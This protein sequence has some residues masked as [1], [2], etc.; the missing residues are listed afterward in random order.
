MVPQRCPSHGGP[1]S[2]PLRPPAYLPPRGPPPPPP[3]LRPGQARR[4][5]H[6]PGAGPT[7]AGGGAI[8]RSQKTKKRRGISASS[9]HDIMI[10]PRT[11]SPGR[12]ASQVTWMDGHGGVVVVSSQRSEGVGPRRGRCGQDPNDRSSHPNGG[13]APG[14]PP[15]HASPARS[16]VGA[17]PTLSGNVGESQSIVLMVSLICVGAVR[18]SVTAPLQTNLPYLGGGG[19]RR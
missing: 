15:L 1:P 8:M 16:C 17:V 7:G 13:D 12:C 3:G 18:D 11:H 5:A 6:N 2:M 14:A 9:Y 10:S 4:P 19:A